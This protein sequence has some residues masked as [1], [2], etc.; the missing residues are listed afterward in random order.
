[1]FADKTDEILKDLN[2]NKL[3]NSWINFEKLVKNSIID[4][5]RFLNEFI[6]VHDGIMHMEN[7][8]AQILHF[9][10]K[11]DV[12][13][14]QVSGLNLE[15]NLFLVCDTDV[16]MTFV[17]REYFL[18]FATNK[19]SYME[20]LLEM[21]LLNNMNLYN[22]LIK[23]DFSTEGRVVYTLQY[24]CEKLK[25]NQKNDYFIV[26]AFINKVKLAKY[27]NISRKQLDK[28]LESLTK[29]EL[30]RIEDKRFYVKIP[31]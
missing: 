23:Y 31:S 16:E 14:Q 10:S 15:K 21:T 2:T 1:M 11:G 26:P 9:F 7:K 28:I 18:N 24:L 13:N 8:N 22:E 4:G 3:D 6:V 5:N 12:I 30:I 29:K 19:P 17:N 20:W 25:T 27:G